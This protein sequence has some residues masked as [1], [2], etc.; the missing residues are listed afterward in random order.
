MTVLLF[1]FGFRY[2]AILPIIAAV[3]I[4][5]VKSF[6]VIKIERIEHV[7]MVG[8]MCHVVKNVSKSEAGVVRLYSDGGKLGFETWSART[9]Q[10]SVIREGTTARVTAMQGIYLIVEQE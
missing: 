3:L 1:K 4:L 9:E 5:V 7:Q 10:T 6:E 2:I 8:K